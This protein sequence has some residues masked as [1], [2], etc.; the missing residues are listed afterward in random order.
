MKDLE[1]R[2]E[3]RAVN[4]MHKARDYSDNTF[5]ADPGFFRNRLLKTATEKVLDAYH[6]G[7]VI[8]LEDNSGYHYFQLV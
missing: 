1:L 3:I 8:I 4:D 7:K 5:F 2:Q 6:S